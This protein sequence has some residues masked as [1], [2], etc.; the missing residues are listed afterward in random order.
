MSGAH[1]LLF[2]AECYENSV[3]E[4]AIETKDLAAVHDYIKES[5]DTYDEVLE[6]MHITVTA[7]WVET[8]K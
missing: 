4:S 8:G 5:A 3:F 2:R 6:Q 7:R 1:E